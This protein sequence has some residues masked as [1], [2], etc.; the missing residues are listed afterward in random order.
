MKRQHQTLVDVF[1][2]ERAEIVWMNDFEPFV[3]TYGIPLRSAWAT[4]ELSS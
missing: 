4:R 2:D 3:G 1:Q